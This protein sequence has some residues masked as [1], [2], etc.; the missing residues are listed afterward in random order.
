LFGKLEIFQLAQ[1]RAQHS[2]ARQAN[3]AA[4]IANADTPGYRAT[5]IMPFTETYEPA[6]QGTVASGLRTTRAAHVFPGELAGARMEQIDRPSGG[7]PSG[8]TVSLEA[9]ML[10]AIDADR[11]HNRAV[12]IYETSLNILRSSLRGSR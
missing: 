7:S 4:N 3:I 12:A 6:R 5:D 8:N 11:A 9:E 10:H 1:L 2:S